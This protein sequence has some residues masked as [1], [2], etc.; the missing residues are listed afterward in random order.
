MPPNTHPSP[1]KKGHIFVPITILLLFVLAVGGYVFLNQKGISLFTP[2]SQFKQVKGVDIS[3]Y[4]KG[5]DVQVYDSLPAGF[6]GELVVDQNSTLVTSSVVVSPDGKQNITV[7]FDS[8]KNVGSL[9]ESYMTYFKSP[10]ISVSNTWRV[11]YSEKKEV[12][13]I[14]SD[15]KFGHLTITLAPTSKTETRATLVLKK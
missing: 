7:A 3:P 2:S 12:S 8:K 1:V 10:I 4:D 6:P 15:G 5:T 14:I 9:Y 13:V 11:V